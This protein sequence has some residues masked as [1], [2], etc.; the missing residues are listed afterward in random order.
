[1][2]TPEQ[3]DPLEAFEGDG[4]RVLSVSAHRLLEA[5]GGLG[6]LLPYR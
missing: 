3:V 1:M 2:V 4:A 6:V 5:G